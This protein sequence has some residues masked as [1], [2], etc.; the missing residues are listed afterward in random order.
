M[1]INQ[2]DPQELTSFKISF[3]D[4][5][6]SLRQEG[7]KMEDK[8][9]KYD[10]F[11][12]S[13]IKYLKSTKKY[14]NQ[15]PN[16]I[17]NCALEN[18]NLF[19]SNFKKIIKIFQVLSISYDP[20]NKLQ[21]FK[22]DSQKFKPLF[23]TL[24]KSNNNNDEALKKEI[25]IFFLSLTK[26]QYSTQ[27]FI[28]KDGLLFLILDL[29]I[30]NNDNYNSLITEILLHTIKNKSIKA[31]NSSDFCIYYSKID[32]KSEKTTFLTSFFSTFA[33]KFDSLKAFSS[34]AREKGAFEKYIYFMS[35]LDSKYW[36]YYDTFLNDGTINSDYLTVLFN[37][38]LKIPKIQ[39]KVFEIVSKYFLN[40]N[41]KELNTY[42]PI[43]RVISEFQLPLDTI[44]EFL[45]RLNHTRPDMIRFCLKPFFK[46]LMT[47]KNII[48]SDPSKLYHSLLG[49]V[50]D[51]IELKFFNEE[52]LL[53]IGFIDTFVINLDSTI[54]LQLISKFKNFTTLVFNMT[55]IMK[56]TNNLTKVEKVFKSIINS[57]LFCDKDM[58][59]SQLS[60]FCY[61]LLEMNTSENNMKALL[62][63]MLQN[64]TAKLL[65]VLLSTNVK[66]GEIF[67]KS[68]G[69]EWLEKA[70][71]MNLITIEKYSI[72]LANLVYEKRFEE[73]DSFLLKLQKEKYFGK[74]DKKDIH[75]L[76]LSDL[77]NIETIVYGMNRCKNKP[78]RVYSLF[79]FLETPKEIDPYNA[80]MLGKY[81]LNL[82]TDKNRPIYDIPLIKDIG[83]RYLNSEHV[84][85]LLSSNPY[86]IQQFCDKINYDHFPLF[87]FF[88]GKKDFVIEEN[89]S[90][91]S[92]WFK[93]SGEI[94]QSCHFFST[95]HIS[96]QIHNQSELIIYF[97]ASSSSA[98]PTLSPNSSKSQGDKFLTR[99]K[100]N[101]FDWN[102]IYFQKVDHF[103]SSTISFYINQYDRSNNYNYFKPSFFE[104]N[105]PFRVKFQDINFR[106]LST[107]LMFLG[108]SLRFF[109]QFDKNSLQHEQLFKLI[110]YCGPGYTNKLKNAVNINLN[111][112]ADVYNSNNLFVGYKIEN[113]T[114]Y[115]ATEIELQRKNVS[116]PPSCFLVPYF[117]FP[118]HFISIQKLSKKLFKILKESQTIDQFN[119]ILFAIIK[120]NSITKVNSRMFWLVLLDI[121]H[122]I[123]NTN[124][125]FI[126]QQL[127]CIL[128]KEISYQKVH[129]YNNSILS[130]LFYSLK[131]W[132]SVDK[133]DLIQ[134][135]F[136]N[137][138]EVDIN[139]GIPDFAYFLSDL[140]LKNPK[141]KDIICTLFKNYEKVPTAIAN[142]SLFL[143]VDKIQVFT[144]SSEKDDIIIYNDGTKTFH[145]FDNEYMLQ[146]K[147]TIISAI[148]EFLDETTVTILKKFFPF[149]DLNIFLYLFLTNLNSK[150]DDD[151]AFEI[152]HLI[153]QISI[154]DPNYF[155]ISPF[156]M[157]NTIYLSSKK[158]ILQDVFNLISRSPNLSSP[159][160]YN[161]DSMYLLLTLTW[162]NFVIIS[163]VEL[164][165]PDKLNT[166]KFFFENCCRSFEYCISYAANI[167]N[168]QNCLTILTTWFPV[169]IK[170]VLTFKNKIKNYDE[171]NPNQSWKD[172]YYH[173]NQSEDKTIID[174]LIGQ[175][176]D[177]FHITI[178][179]KKEIQNLNEE[180]IFSNFH[181][182]KL[183][184]CYLNLL[185]E[186]IFKMQSNSVKIQQSHSGSSFYFTSS[187]NNKNG[188]QLFDQLFLS[189]S[190]C[191]PTFNDTWIKYQSL[192]SVNLFIDIILI[193]LK[194]NVTFC[195]I[196]RFFQFLKPILRKPAYG[197]EMQL[198]AEKLLANPYFTEYYYNHVDEI[199][200]TIYQKVKENS[201][202]LLKIFIDNK[203]K[204][205]KVIHSTKYFLNNETIPVDSSLAWAYC[206]N[207]NYEKTQEYKELIH[208]F[209]LIQE[210]DKI[211][212]ESMFNDNSQTDKEVVNFQIRMKDEFMKKI[213]N[214]QNLYD[215]FSKNNLK[216]N[217]DYLNSMIEFDQEIENSINK[218]QVKINQNKNQIENQIKNLEI[219]LFLF[220]EEKNW[221]NF[222]NELKLRSSDLSEFNPRSYLISSQCLPYLFPKIRK[223]LI[224]LN[225]E[226]PI[227][228]FEKK[229]TINFEMDALKN[230]KT[231]K[232]KQT[233]SQSL[234]TLLDE[235]NSNV[236]Q[237][238]EKEDKN[239]LDVFN[240]FR[241][242]FEKQF[243]QIERCFNCYID[244]YDVLLIPSVLFVF[245][246]STMMILTYA[247]IIQN[248]SNSNT[249]RLLND[250]IKESDFLPFI[251]FVFNQQFG[252]T[253]LFFSH[254][255]IN[256]S[257]TDIIKTNINFNS[258]TNN[259]LRFL[260]WTFSSGHL[261]LS[262]KNCHFD[263][264][265]SLF[266]ES[267]AIKCINN[268][269]EKSIPD[270][271]LL[272]KIKSPES[273]VNYWIE[274]IINNEELLFYLNGIKNNSFVSFSIFPVFP[275]IGG[276]KGENAFQNTM[277]SIFNLFSVK[278]DQM[279]QNF[280]RKSNSMNLTE[281]QQN[282]S[283]FEFHQEEV[284]LN[285]K[286]IHK[287]LKKDFPIT[288]IQS[289]KK[290]QYQFIADFNSIHVHQ[291][292]D[293]RSIFSIKLNQLFQT[294]EKVESKKIV[295]IRGSLFYLSKLEAPLSNNF[296]VRVSR[297]SMTLQILKINFDSNSNSDSIFSISNELQKTFSYNL[298]YSKF[299]PLF[300][301]AKSI[302]SSKDGIYI[303]IDLEFGLSRAYRVIYSNAGGS[304]NLA[305]QAFPIA[306]VISSEILHDEPG[307]SDEVCQSEISGAYSIAA[308][309][310]RE[311]VIMW[312]VMPTES[313]LCPPSKTDVF[314]SQ[315]FWASPAAIHRVIEL[316]KRQTKSATASSSSHSKS[317]TKKEN[318]NNKDNQANINDS[319]INT[320]ENNN[321]S[322]SNDN[323]IDTIENNNNNNQIN[324]N[325]KK[326]QID[327]NENNN[328]AIDNDNKIDNIENNNNNNQ[329]NDNDNKEQIVN[330]ENH[331]NNSSDK[332]DKQVDG[333][334]KQTC[335]K[336]SD[337]D[338]ERMKD[339]IVAFKLDE[340]DG[341]WVA[342]RRR[343]IFY[344]LNAE[345]IAEFDF[346]TAS[347]LGSI[348]DREELLI[349][350]IEV[351]SS[352]LNEPFAII[353]L[354]K[355]EIILASPRFDIR[356]I[357]IKVLN[358]P[359]KSMITSISIDKRGNCAFAAVDSNKV[360]SFWSAFHSRTELLNST[361]FCKCAICKK[362][363]AKTICSSC[364]M[365]ICPNCCIN[366]EGGTNF[367]QSPSA[368]CL[369]CSSIE[370][371]LL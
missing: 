21:N 300:A 272:S 86:N 43:Q 164:F 191:S 94:K 316:N 35:K 71:E 148:S 227:E 230:V 45:S 144:K 269:T 13:S 303:V 99:I 237:S 103:R 188:I 344:S 270:Y 347:Q 286:D 335:N 33:N 185:L 138:S 93:F 330:N 47:N 364:N 360:V 190:L 84:D 44:I 67:I 248:N 203:Q 82:L 319:T 252:K 143:F 371:F 81:S 114:V 60:T 108:P 6:E 113:E 19:N 152:L 184:D 92:F 17:F 226:N 136:D 174:L 162:S 147:D 326:E 80:W 27:E 124:P 68:N 209:N 245:V 42:F 357:E 179:D 74:S 101:P 273:A 320:N 307:L 153:F 296:I 369:V 49:I 29:I 141:N 146:L 78:I 346:T 218:Y 340:N 322:I 242:H 292:F 219:S 329:I 186:I 120:I 123:S 332:N 324:D 166:F 290:K 28:S 155:E 246:N 10:N 241:K 251:T 122:D 287:F 176:L 90:A 140:I 339:E 50:T 299:D 334:N 311:K 288:N 262:I 280:V 161:N 211:I 361:H 354:N 263:D 283:T 244:L 110:R 233:A 77:G 343:L 156:L 3:N 229:F 32:S 362:N 328:Q 106:S 57:S 204:F 306:V 115:L 282:C 121:L 302:N 142:V 39:E 235:I 225:K 126:T 350:A 119:E 259:H 15:I 331:K 207:P 96:F 178:Q 279:S 304:N 139:S 117:G 131:I 315:T 206:F 34:N 172:V 264:V 215:E 222:M 107:G 298:I 256:L 31:T 173:H 217:K 353:G 240:C 305:S 36:D 116:V 5:N 63:F 365:G 157:L 132:N 26:T 135:I 276:L 231:I 20:T 291:L 88:N 130:R 149:N 16:R 59:R 22:I 128:V 100:I 62:N 183:L 205:T 309:C 193:K 266:D 293:T 294:I 25:G 163:H 352:P 232:M 220:Y 367:K 338:N 134:V 169:A 234:S 258:K 228:L 239:R 97:L 254:V 196:D 221:N 91:F 297:E 87:Q 175:I 214:Y 24:I 277:L 195:F 366:I 125:S 102:L 105:I 260:I 46:K 202:D 368:K 137:F 314:T 54:L 170:T 213:I 158:M 327:N 359:H 210:K 289:Q 182:K 261:V 180:K 284:A 23:E 247:E 112:S 1:I 348:S 75:P 53:S 72:L 281:N 40:G 168:S 7:V 268:F 83:N 308:S 4:F 51:Q 48:S 200:F 145:K 208:S 127:I 61:N 317:D 249:I 52:S 79:H 109:G 223:P 301:V 257:L 341:V 253:T 212:F 159:T 358:S 271:L 95:N 192:K 194:S 2:N 55:K 150:K 38:C 171:T 355:G 216:I 118:Y 356:E 154:L 64:Q 313:S 98:I 325:D 285:N 318:E 363:D 295:F 37:S 133:E 312:Y 69:L 224:S 12:D 278:N 323:K 310:C 167:L 181:F 199:L 321:Q 41:N 65:N 66:V 265:K 160:Y 73:V 243:G 70:L 336:V 267:S 345:K 58:L 104:T 151:L 30:Y 349:T 177:N 238:S 274:Q 11:L 76:F 201:K 18:S 275:S 56:N 236:L 89:F 250:Q 342:T 9:I 351:C 187:N 337:D 165:E 370:H 189:F 198:I 333:N 111:S 129:L 85:M 14:T 255:V 197:E 8:I